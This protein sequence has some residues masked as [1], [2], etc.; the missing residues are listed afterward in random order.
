MYSKPPIEVY[1]HYLNCGFR[2]AVSSGSDKMALNPPMGSA[3]AYVKTE[4]PLSYDSWVEGIRKGRTFISNYPLIEF[5][6]NG[7][8]PGDT[9]SVQPGKVQL[10][11]KAR[12]VSLEPYEV[13]EIIHNGEIV[14]KGE[15]L[16]EELRCRSTGKH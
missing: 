2:V 7:K 6:V 11:V 16:R 3:R 12:A 4:G 5:S 8:E 9:L 13:L 1:Y 14:R 10:M 15:T